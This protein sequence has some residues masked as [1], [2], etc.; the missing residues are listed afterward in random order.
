MTPVAPSTTVMHIFIFS[1]LRIGLVSDAGCGGSSH[2]DP[3]PV[4]QPST[5]M[6][7]PMMAEQ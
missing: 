5:A 1:I 3:E 6:V 4:P 7:L 2:Q